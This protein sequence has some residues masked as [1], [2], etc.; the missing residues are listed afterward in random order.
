[1]RRL[2]ALV[3]AVILVDTMFYAAIAPLL[4]TYADDL[5][6]SKTAA[7]ILSA[8]Y[9]AGTLVAS[10]PAGFFAAR[11]GVRQAMLVGLSLLGAASLAFAFADDVV[12]LDLARFAQGVGGACAWTG[13]LAWVVA[14]APRERR[15]ALIGSVLAVAIFGIMLGPVL[16]GIASVAG[17]EPVFGA[18]AVL[19]GVVAIQAARTPAAA[20][21]PPPPVRVVAATMLQ[22]PIVTAVWLVALPSLFSGTLNVLVPLRLDE[23]GASGLAVGAVFLTAA[24]VEAVISPSIGSLSDRL[25]RMTPIRV[26]LLV[27]ALMALVLPLP[28]QAL[29]L[30]VVTVLVVLAMSLLWTPAMALL[31]D[32]SERAGLDLAFAA[33]LVNLAWA[34]GQVSGGSVGSALAESTSDA[35]AYA[36]IAALFVLTAVAV[37]G[38]R[39]HVLATGVLAI[40]FL[41]LPTAAIAAKPFS[42][43]PSCGAKGTHADAFCFRGDRPTAVFRAFGRA[44]VSYRVCLRAPGERQRC[45]ERRTGAPGGRSRTAFDV[46]GPGRYRLAWFEGGRAVDRDALVI[47]ERSVFAVGDSLGEGTKPYL[48][49]ALDGW[50]VEQSVSVSRHAPQ[51]VSIL[52]RRSHLPS[53]V[54]F[55][56]GTNDDPRTVAAFADAIRSVIRL[57]GRTRCVVV[58][59]IVR[60][61]VGGVGYGGY[62]RVLAAAARHHANVRVVDWAALV[63]RNRGWLADDGVHVNPSGYMAR[64]RAIAKQVERC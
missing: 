16:G 6:L 5:G 8:S 34:G 1:M 14:S 24:A 28:E 44:R 60:P 31:S 62:N 29:V 47:R 61:P 55:A 57:A 4:P 54:V 35:A 49:G 43:Y 2:F 17:S 42:A 9:A 51:G 12:I 3:A 39:R 58:P 10:I 37:G 22:R 36:A 11:V 38:W 19:A 25:G 46:D 41:A 27:S 64:A 53:V 7:G 23:L 21:E 45:R 50:R 20:P 56:L 33:A 18:V 52:R 40:A 32:T 30:A 26:G 13:G 59:N 63:A 48:P 15:G